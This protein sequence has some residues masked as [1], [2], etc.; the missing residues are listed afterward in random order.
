MRIRSVS[1]C[2]IGSGAG[3]GLQSCLQCRRREWG[4]RCRRLHFR[5]YHGG[6]RRF[7]GGMGPMAGVSRRRLFRL[8]R[9]RGLDF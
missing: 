2:R 4:A 8:R 5:C 1:S 3:C 6:L 7:R 9:D